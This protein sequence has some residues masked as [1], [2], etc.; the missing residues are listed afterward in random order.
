M[1]R[2]PPNPLIRPHRKKHLFPNAGTRERPMMGY[3][4]IFLKNLDEMIKNCYN[5][6]NLRLTTPMA[7]P[8]ERQVNEEARIMWKKHA[9]LALLICLT[10]VLLCGCAKEPT[11]YPE[12]GTVTTRQPVRQ[13]DVLSRPTEAPQ[14]IV[15]FPEEDDDY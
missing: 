5:Y 10:V 3:C 1:P 14:V 6:K 9:A 15:D 8:A 4:N 11:T 13:A 2:R 12:A 7:G